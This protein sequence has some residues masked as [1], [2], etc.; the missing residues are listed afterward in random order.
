MFD[1]MAICSEEGLT[2]FGLLLPFFR[3]V[4]QFC[5]YP[6]EGGPK[7][8]FVGNFCSNFVVSYPLS[9]PECFIDSLSSQKRDV[10]DSFTQD[11]QDKEIPQFPV[12]TTL[13]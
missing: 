8:V 9:S 13:D 11:P 5:Q 7:L 4:D 1:K 12:V 10:V 3:P 2:P 6:R